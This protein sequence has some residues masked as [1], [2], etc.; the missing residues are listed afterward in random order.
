MN[1]TSPNHRCLYLEGEAQHGYFTAAQARA[2]GFDTDDL[3][4]HTRTGRFIRVRRGIYRLRDFPPFYREHLMVPVL[5]VGIDDAVVSHQSALELLELSDIIPAETHLTVPR[6]MRYR[7]NRPGV[8]IHT[9]TRELGPQETTIREGIR[10]TAPEVTIADAAEI[11]VGP[12]QIEMAIQQAL[13]RG[14]TTERRL[15]R[16]ADLHSQ[17]VRNLINQSI[18]QFPR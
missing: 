16:E 12:E 11:G 10:I 9:T 8:I 3:A 7:K 1:A 4:Y 13:N 5:E 6:S 18:D 15:R 14:I 17:R 2:C